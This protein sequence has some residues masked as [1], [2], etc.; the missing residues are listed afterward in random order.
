[1]KLTNALKEKNKLTKKI[2]ELQKI[3]NQHNSVL[4]GNKR[5]FEIIEL[6]NDLDSTTESLV[7]LKN[8]ISLANQP[9]NLHLVKMSEL[10]SQIAFLRKLN[11]KDGHQSERYGQNILEY[12]AQVN[13]ND[14]MK[15]IQSKESEI[16]KMQDLVDYHNVVTEI[17][18]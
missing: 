9:I 13:Q 10:R 7:K 16:E 17:T 8:A 15:I 18:I 2:A 1:M 14:V 6:M 11:V 4:K 12:E 5:Q 3:I